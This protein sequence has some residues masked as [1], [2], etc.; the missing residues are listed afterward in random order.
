MAVQLSGA[1][2]GTQRSFRLPRGASHSEPLQN[3]Q[4]LVVFGASGE[5]LFQIDDFGR[6]GLAPSQPAKYPHIYVLLTA[7]NAFIIPQEYKK[8]WKEHLDEITRPG[9]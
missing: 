1:L 4:R 7:T 3:V 8:T 6:T 2:K 9:I 5:L